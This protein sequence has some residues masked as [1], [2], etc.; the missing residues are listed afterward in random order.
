MCRPCGPC[1][2]GRRRLQSGRRG[3]PRR[4]V[5]HH[6]SPAEL[7]AVQ[8]QPGARPRHGARHGRGAHGRPQEGRPLGPRELRP[9]A[10]GAGP[11]RRRPVSAAPAAAR[12]E[13]VRRARAFPVRGVVALGAVAA[14]VGGAVFL[15]ALGSGRADR[16]WQAYHVNFMFW[17]GLAQASVVFA[18]TQKLAKGHWSGVVIRFAEAAAPFLIVA[19]ALFLGL[20]FGRQHVFSWLHEPRPDIGPW[21]TTKFFFVRNGLVLAGLAWLSWRFVRHDLEPDIRELAEGRAADRL[22]NRDRISREAAILIVAF[23]FGH[24]LLAF[25]L[26]MSLAHKW[27][28]NLFGAF[29]FMG[30][31]LA[32][33]MALAVGAVLLRRA[34]RLGDLI[35]PRQLHDLGKLCFGFTVFWGYLMWAQFLVIW[36]GNL[37]EETYF[38]FYR[39]IGQWKPVGVAVFFLVLVIPFVGLLGVKPKRSPPILLARSEEHTSEL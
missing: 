19:L 17:I 36:Y 18:A 27:V 5:R 10:A 2:P 35:S 39:L 33:L 34:M 6:A 26:M 20:F 38:I 28:S 3:A 31:F 14:L 29:Y 24:S 8:P 23:A 7:Q 37:P 32:A 30:S 16:A 13:L 22:E 12:A 11:Q 21:L 9:D 4:L 15:W 1:R 25:D